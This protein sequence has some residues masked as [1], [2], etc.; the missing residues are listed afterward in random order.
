MTNLRHPALAAALLSLCAINAQQLTADYIK[1][2]ASTSLPT[3]VK[4]WKAGTLDMEDENFFIARVRPHATFR[5][6]AT[7]IN[8]SLTEANDK[9]LVYWVPLGDQTSDLNT[10][11]LPNGLFNSEVFSM[12]S[13]VT[14]FGNWT[15]PHGW[16]P[17]AFADVAHKNGV[18]VSGVASIPNATLSSTS[19]YNPMKEQLNLDSNDLAAFLLAHGVDG[20]GYNSEFSWDSSSMTKLEAQH[21]AVVKYLQAHGDDLAENIWYDGTNDY[22]SITFDQG[23]AAHN[24]GCFGSATD[25]TRT[26]SLFLNYNWNSSSQLSSSVTYAKKMGLDPLYLYAGFNMQG[27]QPS[28]NNWPTLAKYAISIGLWGAHSNNMMWLAR[29]S[30]G[31]TPAAMQK[32]YQKSIEQW[33]GNGPRNPSVAISVANRSKCSPDDDFFGMSALMTARSALSWDLSEEPFISYFNLGNGTFFNWMGSRQNSMEWY[34]IGV[35]DYMPTWRFWW[36]KSLLATSTTKGSIGLDATFTWDDAYVGGSCLNITGT[37]ADAYL[38]LFKTRFALQV[39]DKIRVTY[40]LRSGSTAANLILTTEGAEATAVRENSLGVISADTE[41]DE[42][43][44]TTATFTV[45]GSLAASL[46]G[47]NLALIGLH[48]TDAKALDL[49]L[50]EVSIIRGSAATPATP[51]V[52]LTRVLANHHLGIDG[53]IIFN[54]PATAKADGTPTYN[55][56]VATSMFKIYAQEEGS[57]PVFV[58]L[59]T[60]WAGMVYSFPVS[61]ANNR[62]RLGVS[63]M[64]LDH[65]SDSPIAWGDW[66]D[67]G[68]Y[69]V[70]D[71]IQLSQNVIK[72]NEAFSVGYVDPQHSPSNWRLYD[73]D[74]NLMA[75]ATSALEINLPNGLP[76]VGGYDV[77]IDEGTDAQRTFGYFVQISSTE[78]GAIPRILTTTVDGDSTSIETGDHITLRYTGR[79]AD[80]AGS[81]AISLNE[82]WFG[83]KVSQLGLQANQSFSV[84]GWVRIDN[85]PDGISNFVTIENRDG[86]WPANNWG[87]FWSRIAG[88]GR[89]AYNQIDGCWGLRLQAAA[90]GNRLFSQYDNSRIGL[91]TW[92][93]F[94]IV[95]EYNDEGKVRSS[96]YLNG[97]KQTMS[98]WLNVLKSSYDSSGW[99]WNDLQGYV[100]NYGNNVY[101]SGVNATETGYAET[102]YTLTDN[103]YIAF[104][105]SASNIFALQGALDDFQVWGRAMTDADVKA[106][107]EGLDEN[108]LP[109]GL[110]ALFDFE[111]EPNVKA[112][113]AK[114]EKAGASG[115]YWDTTEGTKEGQS[116]KNYTVPNY[117][118][119]CPF[120]KGSAYQVVTT[121]QWSAK[122]GVIAPAEGSDT[123]GSADLTYRKAGTFN[124]TLTL[125]NSHGSDTAEFP[126]I[127]VSEGASINEVAADAAATITA[128]TGVV[129]IHF[130]DAS[131]T[132]VVNVYNAAG[133]LVAT[134]RAADSDMTLRISTPGAYIVS[135]AKANGAL[136][137]SANILVP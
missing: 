90:D 43:L 103:D 36:S 100:K 132:H 49:L 119:G 62:V 27:G 53:K 48:F 93:H 87:Y 96:F 47:K 33:F 104:G 94:A 99:A 92:T 81:R 116:S 2:P 130:A 54:M 85:L 32:T 109:E 58:G 29:N 22:G 10:N 45:S 75:E 106:S 98:S 120:I 123:E 80:G 20:L 34:N 65:A 24:D 1:W 17:G 63:A 134:A 35:Q 133:A 78:T 67:K 128:A 137:R 70:T 71:D 55:I 95:F 79:E 86:S 76:Q 101:G 3:Y 84:A 38:Q 108:N 15:S 126:V 83:V 121:P 14:H 26:A 64:S 4:A 5:N 13:Y 21:N 37:D 12:W 74:G 91:G 124:V 68:E 117:E 39:G 113:K 7:Q 40:K 127:N 42:D 16:V 46:N 135:I 56:D 59:T 23:L 50:G 61:S 31:S 19:W 30:N 125:T 69:T 8:S 25:S 41:S 51:E 118:A 105:G 66:M 6:A 89:F 129:L 60:S 18:A 28:T 107:M 44:W 110:L 102:S 131:E 112:F 114:G 11:A 77:V 88:D 115:F 122:K 111:D 9:R 73:K 57:E 52:T 97:V 136:V 72:P 82:K